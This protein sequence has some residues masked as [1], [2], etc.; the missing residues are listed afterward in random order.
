MDVRISIAKNAFRRDPDKEQPALL[1]PGL[2]HGAIPCPSLREEL[3]A[4]REV[5]EIV[6]GQ[7]ENAYMLELL[8]LCDNDVPSACRCSGLSRARLYELLK[9]HCIR[10]K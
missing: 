9:K 4:L 1:E 5:R 7:L 10:L 8:K 2:M 6:V 3:P